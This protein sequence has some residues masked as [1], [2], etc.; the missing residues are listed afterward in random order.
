[1]ISPL[2]ANIFLHYGFDTWMTREYPGVRFE[3]FADDVVVHCVTERQAHQVWQAIGRRFAD[4]GLLLHPD[5]TRIVYCKDDRRRLGYGQVTFTFCG[6]AFRPRMTFVRGKSRTGFLPAVAPGKLTDM[7][8]K[9]ASWRLH[10]RTTGNL[11]D[12]AAEVNPALRGWLNYFTAF[13]PSA[14]NPIGKR[15]D[16]HLMRWATWKYKR[17]KHSDNRARMWLRGVRQRS[18]GLFVH[19]TL[20][21]TT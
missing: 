10:R 3:R 19:W 16:R 1:V 17:L 7:S 18:P 9:V 15:M 5:K 6:Y 8:R 12:L 2:I 11:A 21:Y 13:Y 4:I 14:V 20:R